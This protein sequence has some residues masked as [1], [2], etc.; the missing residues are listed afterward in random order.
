MFPAQTAQAF[1]DLR[2]AWLYPIHNGTFDLAMHSWDEPLEQITRLA[3]E[4]QI[5]LTTPMMGESLTLLTPHGG[6]LWWRE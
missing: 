4:Q 3:A 5:P 1:H 2:A 6:S